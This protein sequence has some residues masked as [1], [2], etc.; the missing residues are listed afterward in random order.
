M[1]KK[2][3]KVFKFILIG[4]AFFIIFIIGTTAY[5]VHS[6]HEKYGYDI[7]ENYKPFEPSILYDINGNQIDIIN[8]QNSDPISISEVPEHV[9]NAFIAIEDKRFRDHHGLDFIRLTKA[10]FLNVT[11]TGSEGGSTITQQLIK[12]IFLTP[13]RSIIKRKIPEAVLAV[14]MERKYTKDEILEN[15]LNSINFGRGA[16]GIKNA[17]IKYFNK[18]PNNLTIA[19][20]AILASIP[21][22]PTKYSKLENVLPR[23][24]VV[25]KMMY[26]NGFIT[27]EEY[28]NAKL[29]EIVFFN[30]KEDGIEESIS[31]TNTAP[32]FTTEVIKEA[33]KILNI[34][35]D[36]I[37]KLFNGYKIYATL[38]INIQK[39]A[40]KAFSTSQILKNNEEL[41]GALISVDPS[42]GYVKAMVGGKDY[43]KGNFNRATQAI[44]QPGS[45]FKP[46]IYLSAIQNNIP[47]NLV[48]EDRN[49]SFGK[50][51]PRNYDGGHKGGL[52]ILR[53]I[54][55]S[56][57]IVAVK[58]LSKVGLNSAL[59]TWSKL[60]IETSEPPRDLTL[61][62]GSITLTPLD[63]AKAYASL[64]NGGYRVEPQFIYKIENR[65]GEVIYE[66]K[67]KPEKIYEEED[68]AILTN[69]LQSV[70][71][72]GTAV[73]AKVYKNGKLINMAGK[74]GT[75]NDAVSVWFAGYTPTL[76][77]VVYVGYDNNKSIGKKVTGGSVAIPIWRDYMQNV[78]AIPNYNVG[79]FEFIEK[80]LS[81]G[82]IVRKYI[83]AY[84]GLLD[85]DSVNSREAY[86]KSGF[87][88]V[89]TE[90]SIYDVFGY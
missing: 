79:S 90:G 66:S 73:G 34:N 9:Q 33:M 76:S 70:V 20:A 22:S 21:K 87:E 23:Q 89:E 60:N 61:A 84:S 15:Y 52:T 58:T 2:L 47:L 38:D 39:A 7:I 14:E 64:A 83:D 54:E 17:S 81:R 51:T 19:Q 32:E 12:N 31:G 27:S 24:K 80:A 37:E 42:N 59:E 28:E 75:T 13:E 85:S 44:R 68:V 41:E 46:F 26:K 25:L 72:N 62:L 36:E 1:K 35:E 10:I 88:P 29:E 5:F 71:N 74:T 3:R 48:V 18:L 63:L 86:F 67:S 6:V 57:N 4:L 16:Y 30:E 49:T 77:T 45:A 40:Y 55:L 43:I 50:Y 82:K 53:A 11:G 65:L 78:V 69:A 56:N 8:A